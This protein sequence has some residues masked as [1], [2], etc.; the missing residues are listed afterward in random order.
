MQAKTAENIQKQ[1][2]D[3]TRQNLEL[4]RLSSSLGQTGP[5]DL[6]RWQGEIATAKS[7]LLNA[8]A[9]RRLAELALNQ[10]LN[11]PI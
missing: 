1:N 5:S 11:R 8:T 6:L 4:A 10:I 9:Q 3:V 7:N 2:L